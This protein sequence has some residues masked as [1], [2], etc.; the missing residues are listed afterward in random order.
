MGFA[1]PYAPKRAVREDYLAPRRSGYD[2]KNAISNLVSPIDVFRSSHH[3]ATRWMQRNLTDDK[4]TMVQVMAWCIQVTNHYLSQCWP[5]SMSPYVVTRPQFVDMNC[6]ITQWG[7][8]THYVSAKRTAFVSVSGMQRVWYQIIVCN[9]TGVPSL[10]HTRTHTTEFL[11]NQISFF[12][13]NAF[14]IVV[15]K[16]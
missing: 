7:I 1:S 16:M 13:E 11:E 4:S 5:R 14:E 10:K 6:C 9:N 3:N 15:N 8:V 2:F 12:Q